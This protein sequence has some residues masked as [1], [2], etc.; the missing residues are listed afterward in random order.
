MK[1]NI[2]KESLLDGLLR[3]GKAISGKSTLPALS[4]VFLEGRNNKLL[5]RGTD[6]DISIET[7]VEAEILN[8]GYLLVDYKVFLEVI[9]KLPNDLIVIDSDEETGVNIICKKSHFTLTTMDH[10]DFPVL[11]GI[12]A[13]ELKRIKVSQSDFK[14]M[15]SKV[16][17]AASIDDSRPIL[18]GILLEVKNKKLTLVGLDGYRL[19]MASIYI[20]SDEDISSVADTKHLLEVSKLLGQTGIVEIGFTSNNI[21]LKTN[22]TITLCRLLE[23]NYVDYNSIAGPFVNEY[24][25]KLDINKNEFLS[26]IDRAV[27]LSKGNDGKNLIKLKVNEESEILNICS[28]SVVGKSTEDI[29]INNSTGFTQ[30]FEIAF[31]AIYLTDVLKSIDNEDV[32]LYFTSNNS[33][34]IIRGKDVSNDSET[35]LVLPVRLNLVK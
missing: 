16:Y 20:D 24:K 7:V 21:L 23:G 12:N 13:N 4:G 3:V 18:K 32:T 2:S 10:S 33:P 25:Y 5:I 34:C 15:I 29:N 14:T 6:I 30:A 19:S 1:I 26:A 35:F 22:N 31:N 28:R 27:L 17:F 11:G 9:R 8:A